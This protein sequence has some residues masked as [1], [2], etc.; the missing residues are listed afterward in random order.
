M[1]YQ[2]I[3]HRYLNHC[4]LIKSQVK[5]HSTPSSQDFINS[6]V[7]VLKLYS[8][9][10][11][12]PLTDF[13]SCYFLLCVKLYNG[14][15][16]KTSVINLPDKLHIGILMQLILQVRVLATYL[17]VVAIKDYRV[18]RSSFLCHFFLYGLQQ[19]FLWW[20]RGRE[21]RFQICWIWCAPGILCTISTHN[22]RIQ[23]CQPQPQR[24]T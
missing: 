9:N 24:G 4:Y 8:Q 5:F 11:P 14:E 12:K 20:V 17:G 19:K 18:I 1:F 3:I 6:H 13:T 15:N 2:N 22:S 23:T 21:H 7:S 10:K 16:G